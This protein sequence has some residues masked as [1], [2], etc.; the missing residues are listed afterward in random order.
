MDKQRI[1]GAHAR[2]ENY[3]E[4][5]RVLGVTRGTA[6]AIVRDINNTVLL[7]GHVVELT[8]RAWTKR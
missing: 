7:L 2:H 3:V 8:T 4:V 6:Y 1:I 5:T